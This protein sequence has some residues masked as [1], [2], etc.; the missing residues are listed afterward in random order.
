MKAV[1]ITSYGDRPAVVEVDSPRPGPGEVVVRVAGAALNP[2]DLKIAA[3]SVHDYFPVEF[4]YTLG[5]DVSGTVASTG[6]TRAGWDVGDRVVARLDPS[7]GGAFA[8]EVVVPVDQL[9]AA[10]RSL[11]LAHAAG[12]V[13]T[14]ATA[15][16]AL[17]EVAGL[18]AGQTILVHAGAGGVGT[19]AVQFARALGAHVI[20][21]ASGRG[22][23]IARQMGAHQVVDHTETDFRTVVPRVDVVLDTVGGAV[24]EDSLDVLAA[25]GVLVATPAP[26]DDERA[27]ARGV[28]ARFVFHQSDAERLADV[29]NRIDEGARLVVDSTSPLTEAPAALARLAAGRAKGKLLLVVDESPPG[30]VP[31]RGA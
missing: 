8:E 27:R 26:P 1:Q 6:S 29:V 9:V 18:R 11:P 3:G 24:E 30:R 10:P 16:Q 5:T 23:E 2:L 31:E 15:W 22:L 17:T 28:R 19:F 4:P 14:A 7:R 20:S 13:T 12:V 21:T 25:G